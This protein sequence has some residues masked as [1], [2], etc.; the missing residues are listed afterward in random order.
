[1]RLMSNNPKKFTGLA[2]FGLR[3]VERV[4]SHTTPNPENIRYL[5]TKLERMGHMLGQLSND[6]DAGG[7]EARGMWPEIENLG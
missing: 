6:A 2:G 5:Q 4:P 1:M 3:I 7:D